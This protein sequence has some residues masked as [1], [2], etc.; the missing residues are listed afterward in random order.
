MAV[1][2]VVPGLA[3][4]G[5]IFCALLAAIH[6]YIFVLEALLWRSRAAKSF[7]LSQTAVDHSVGLASNQGF[8]NLLLAA[9][10]VWSTAEQDSRAMLFFLAAVFTAGVFG[11]VTASFRIL[12]VQV[13]PSLLGFIF[14]AFGYFTTKDWSSFRHPLYA[15][16]ILFGAGLV[17]FILAF[18]IKKYFLG[19]GPKIPTK[20]TTANRDT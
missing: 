11:A 4:T 17:T 14:V 18:I 15:L 1:D 8:Y 9:G 12:F 19:D 20:T 16:L 10:L 2:A 6:I 13:I 5:I 7:G 3:I